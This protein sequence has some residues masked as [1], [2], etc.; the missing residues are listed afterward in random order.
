MVRRALEAHAL[1]AFVNCTRGSAKLSTA[2]LEQQDI[3]A[4]LREH[5]CTMHMATDK[6]RDACSASYRALCDKLHLDYSVVRNNTT[7]KR[8]RGKAAWCVS[9]VVDGVKTRYTFN[10]DVRN[11]LRAAVCLY[12]VSVLKLGEAVQFEADALVSA[13]ETCKFGDKSLMEFEEE[14]SNALVV[15]TGALQKPLVVT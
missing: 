9:V 14:I 10:K 12:N 15:V 11:A 2:L 13:I 1:D 8:V 3:D 6:L 5:I 7:V 4:T